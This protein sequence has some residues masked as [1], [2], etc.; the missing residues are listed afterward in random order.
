[1]YYAYFVGGRDTNHGL[2]A[3]SDE[4][5]PSDMYV[6]DTKSS[7]LIHGWER[8]KSLLDQCLSFMLTAI[9]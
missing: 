6:L 1:M 2:P 4:S 3:A 9:G 8:L 5:S 7:K